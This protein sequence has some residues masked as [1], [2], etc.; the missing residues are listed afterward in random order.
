MTLSDV[1]KN[2]IGGSLFSS[3]VIIP[4]ENYI[5]NT[6]NLSEEQKK[7]YRGIAVGAVGGAVLGYLNGKRAHGESEYDI[8]KKMLSTA[9]GAGFGAIAGYVIVQQVKTIQD[10]NVATTADKTLDNAT[11][12]DFQTS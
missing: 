8:T 4:V 7:K 5:A 9:V 2:I 12:K 10:I 6:P 1:I 3:V 11:S